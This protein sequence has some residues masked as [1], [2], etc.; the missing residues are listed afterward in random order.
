VWT[1]DK[2]DPTTYTLMMLRAVA[3]RE[4]WRVQY[5]QAKAAGAVDSHSATGEPP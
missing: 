4:R 1:D 2:P 3:E 5:D